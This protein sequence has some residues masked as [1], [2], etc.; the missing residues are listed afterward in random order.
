MGNPLHDYR[1]AQLDIRKDFDAF[2]R[3]H[4]A[5]CPAPCCVKPARI[6]PTDVLLAEAHGWRAKVQSVVG[7][8]A[9]Q[10]AAAGQSAAINA[11]VEAMPRIPC[12]H[13]SSTG[14][15]FPSDLRP[16][17]CTTYICPIMYERMD[18]KS[19]SRLKRKVKE[20]THAHDLLM[21]ALN[22]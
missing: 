8:D 19:L 2:T 13:L 7:Q 20:L 22:R 6:T 15:S 16:F 5:T 18:R 4:C 17:G 10:S 3:V 1:R 11:D 12:E 14:C 21:S 9:V